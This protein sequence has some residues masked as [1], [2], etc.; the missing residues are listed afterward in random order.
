MT[1]QELIKLPSSTVRGNSVY[2]QLYFDLFELEYGYTPEP[3]CCGHMADWYR[4]VGSGNNNQKYIEIMSKSFEIKDRQ[5]IYSFKKDKR[6]VRCYGYNMTENF[7]I[8]YLTIGTEE[9]IESRKL[10]F[11]RL[12]V[13]EIEVDSEIENGKELSFKDL[14]ELY[15]QFAVAKSKKEILALIEKLEA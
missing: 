4:F 12:P 3:P 15:P 6:A 10:E 8:D 9:E 14:K 1:K 5:K 11:K 13:T 2:F 7:A